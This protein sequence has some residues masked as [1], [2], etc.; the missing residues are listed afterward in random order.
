MT[1]AAL[2]PPIPVGVSPLPGCRRRRDRGAGLLAPEASRHRHLIRPAPP[3]AGHPLGTPGLAHVRPGRELRSPQ[4]WSYPVSASPGRGFGG[5]PAVG[6]SQ[7]DSGPQFWLPLRPPPRKPVL[8]GRRG[9]GGGA[10]LGSDLYWGTDPTA[11][12]GRLLQKTSPSLGY[13]FPLS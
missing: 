13:G 4:L 1:R 8:S 7:L 11:N 9:L 10:G 6:R 3:S 5:R 12:A 2:H